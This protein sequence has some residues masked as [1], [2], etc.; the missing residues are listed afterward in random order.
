[1]T[2]ERFEE[3]ADAFARSWERARQAQICNTY[4]APSLPWWVTTLRRAAEHG[5]Q[6]DPA[7]SRGLLRRARGVAARS[8][9]LARRFRNDLPHA[10][11]EQA[12]LR[13]YQGR[14]R[15]AR[16]LFDASLR[17]ADEQ[18]AKY[19]RALTMLARGEAGRK[20]CWHDAEQDIAQARSAIQS[21]QPH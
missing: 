9:R 7:K 12:I 21:M 15:E 3:A 14:V 5:A 2:E 4:I 17:I 19:E 18:G 16:R 8:L 13:A 11:R 20:L 6:I 10:L 1:V